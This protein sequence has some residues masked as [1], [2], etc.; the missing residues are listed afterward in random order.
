MSNNRMLEFFIFISFFCYTFKKLCYEKNFVMKKT[1]F[2]E[3]KSKND[4]KQK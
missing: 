3:K 2:F 4:A 1:F